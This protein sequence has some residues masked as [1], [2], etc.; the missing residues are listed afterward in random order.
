MRRYVVFNKKHG[1]WVGCNKDT[2]YY[3]KIIDKARIFSTKKESED[4]CTYYDKT[5]EVTVKIELA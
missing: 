3:S 5:V 4:F 2:D 1:F